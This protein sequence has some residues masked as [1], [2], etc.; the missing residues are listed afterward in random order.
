MQPPCVVDGWRVLFWPQ[1]RDFYFQDARR[2][3]VTWTQPA[4]VSEMA[5]L[6]E[7]RF[8]VSGAGNV[9]VLLKEGNGEV[10]DYF[11]QLAAMPRGPKH[12]SKNNAQA[13]SCVYSRGGARVYVGAFVAAEDA[14]WLQRSC[15]GLVVSVLGSRQ[16]HPAV[17]CRRKHFQF[18]TDRWDDLDQWRTLVESIWATLE[19]GLSV[20][21]HCMAGI[22]RAPV[23]AAGSLAILCQTS[24]QDAYEL[25]VASGRYVEPWSFKDYVGDATMRSL[26]RCVAE[27]RKSS[28]TQGLCGM[29]D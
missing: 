9:D 17:P 27:V 25:V 5:A 8:E 15:I 4:A 23:C 7:E 18:C 1:H 26:V 22:H 24:F 28:V 21:I 2:G 13:P 19:K 10:G 12:Y 3:N 29:A 14:S 16:R 6:G 11:D 20:L